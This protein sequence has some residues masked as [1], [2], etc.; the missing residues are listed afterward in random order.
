MNDPAWRGVGHAVREFFEPLTWIGFSTPDGEDHRHT[1]GRRSSDRMTRLVAVATSVA[2][3]VTII[4]SIYQSNRI[5]SLDTLRHA[6]ANRFAI[7]LAPTPLIAT[8]KQVTIRGKVAADVVLATTIVTARWTVAGALDVARLTL[9]PA[10]RCANRTSWTIYPPVEV[11]DDGSFESSI[12]L[13]QA[14]G[15]CEA[16]LLLIERGTLRYGVSLPQLPANTETSA[17]VIIR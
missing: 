11:K 14:A 9:V 13:N 5:R 3:V 15:P 6:S 2:A 1:E 10:V 7:R 4:T 8:H 12:E 17:V 16:R